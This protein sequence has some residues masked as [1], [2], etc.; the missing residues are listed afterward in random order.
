MPHQFDEAASW[1]WCRYDGLVNLLE[2]ETGCRLAGPSF[3]STLG[4]PCGSILT[5]CTDHGGEEG[6]L[7]SNV[8]VV[9]VVVVVIAVVVVVI[10]VFII[11]VV[12]VVVIIIMVK[13]K[14]RKRMKRSR[15]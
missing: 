10:V 11:V 5:V 14:R 15:Y 3:P 1:Y 13:S 6:L 4:V 12:V 2:G 7:V 9:I 8:L